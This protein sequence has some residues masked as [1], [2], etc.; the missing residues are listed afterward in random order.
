[1][2][3]KIQSDKTKSLNKIHETSLENDPLYSVEFFFGY[4][5][6]LMSMTNAG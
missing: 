3:S 2:K 4:A 1:M 5:P 6:A